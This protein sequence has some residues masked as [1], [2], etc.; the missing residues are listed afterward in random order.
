MVKGCVM[1][2]GY[3]H[4]RWQDGRTAFHEGQ[5][6]ALLVAHLNALGL[7]EGARVFLPLCGKARD[8]GWLRERG[9]R[10]AGCEL[11]EK[12]IEQLFDDLGETPEIARQGALTRYSAER[13]EIF[14]GDFFDLDAETLGPVDAVYDRAA[15]VAL[16][17]EMRVRYTAHLASV[18][19][20]ARQLLIAFDY[21]QNEMNG[22]PFSVPQAEVH[23]HY[24]TAFAVEQLASVPVEGGLKGK[25]AA[26]EEVYLLTAR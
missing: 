13:I 14:V 25:C 24:E 1:E 9:F 15:L 26:Q 21:D 11:S 19:A 7:A 22:P 18:T 23:E 16:P 2:H 20:K 17:V 10:I 5:A 3:W 6:N 12:A 8:I 4:E